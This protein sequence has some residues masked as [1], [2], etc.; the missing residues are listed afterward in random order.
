MTNLEI[1]N[2]NALCAELTSGDGIPRLTWQQHGAAFKAPVVESL[3]TGTR[4]AAWDSAT[5]GTVGE[6]RHGMYDVTF[7][8]LEHRCGPCRYSATQLRPW[9]LVG[10]AS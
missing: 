6:L 3:A 5:P 9:P 2:H 8:D 7:P 4:V 1:E 10:G